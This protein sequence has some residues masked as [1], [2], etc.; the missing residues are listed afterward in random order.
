MSPKEYRDLVESFLS[1]NTSADDFQTQYFRAFK[2]ETQMMPKPLFM[3]L[4][5]VF[6]DADA[7]SPLW[8]PQDEN[9]YRITEVTL[10]HRLSE[11][12][13]KLDQY[14]KNSDK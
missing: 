14:L 10:R 3:I 7:Y 6:L 4:E 9:S 2:S 5:N 1:G 8:R 12:M 11:A 13:I